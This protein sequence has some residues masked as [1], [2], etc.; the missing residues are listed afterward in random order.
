ME[1]RRKEQRVAD[2]DGYKENAP[3]VENGIP[4]REFKSHRHQAAVLKER[5]EKLKKIE[6][7]FQTKLRENRRK[8]VCFGCGV[9]MN[10]KET[11]NQGQY[12]TEE[13]YND[14]YFKE[15]QDKNNDL[16]DGL[17][18]CEQVIVNR[19]KKVKVQHC[20]KCNVQRKKQGKEDLEIMRTLEPEV[21]VPKRVPAD[22]MSENSR[23]HYTTEVG[24]SKVMR[25]LNVVETMLCS[26]LLVFAQTSPARNEERGV[27]NTRSRRMLESDM[28]V[29]EQYAGSM[30]PMVMSFQEASYDDEK[31]SEVLIELNSS[32]PNV[33]KFRTVHERI[34]GDSFLAEERNYVEMDSL[35][36]TNV[37]RFSGQTEEVYPTRPRN[38]MGEM[39]EG[40]THREGVQGIL[41]PL[42][43]DTHEMDEMPLDKVAAGKIVDREGVRSVLHWDEDVEGHLFPTLFPD[44]RGTYHDMV[45]RGYKGFSNPKEYVK[46]RLLNSDERWRN[47]AVWCCF[48]FDHL[49]KL[50]C[51][52][53]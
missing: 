12:L 10:K 26:M 51:T 3:S 36:H 34:G 16:E 50:K 4:L 31:L 29:D 11:C 27:G 44:G 23:L 52:K 6:D 39:R 35:V 9:K 1:R 47:N 14:S 49:E 28:R 38:L 45:R 21:D 20:K 53:M 48:W 33:K 43:D 46:W 8:F 37:E 19:K 30:G 41:F 25:C 2:E 42:M 17:I 18:F 5:E 40:R 22:Y 13:E 32:N 15:W 24:R 7:V